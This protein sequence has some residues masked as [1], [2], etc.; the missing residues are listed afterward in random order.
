MLK[1]FHIQGMMQI[2]NNRDTGLNVVTGIGP[3]PVSY[4]KLTWSTIKIWVAIIPRLESVS[5]VSTI[6]S[7]IWENN[8]TDYLNVTAF[9]KWDTQQRTKIIFS[10]NY[11]LSTYRPAIPIRLKI[12]I[13][14]LTSWALTDVQDART[15]MLVWGVM[16]DT[17]GGLAGYNQVRCDL[18]TRVTFTDP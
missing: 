6:L 5:N 11:V 16:A 2:Y 14:R 7:D 18:D 4:P 17:S 8:N 12:P 10:K 13:K 1:Y 9:K 15:N 3:P